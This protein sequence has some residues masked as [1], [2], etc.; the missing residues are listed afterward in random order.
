MEHLRVKFGDPSCIGFWDII[1]K[2][3]Q[4]NS[5]ENFTSAPAVVVCNQPT[6]ATS[7]PSACDLYK[8]ATVICRV[9]VLVTHP[10]LK[11]R[12]PRV[13]PGQS[14]LPLILLL[15]HLLLYLLVSNI[16]LFS[17]AYFLHLF[18]C[19]SIPSHSTRIT[20]PYFKAGCR[21]RRLN[22]ALVFLIL[23]FMYFL[24]KDACLFLSYLI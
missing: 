3:R 8:P 2:N 12:R 1:Q 16:F 21:R 24:V 18:S 23:C 19:F 22:L 5:G 17:L 13:G 6:Y 15:P 11:K 14:F 10:K 9:S 4:T 7:V 20:P